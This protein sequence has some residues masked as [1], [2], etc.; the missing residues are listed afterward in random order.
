MK[1]NTVTEQLF[2]GYITAALWSSTDDGGEPLDR[3]YSRS[4]ISD[5]AIEKM[6]ADCT[7]FREQNQETLDAS[8]LDIDQ[9][10]HDFWL[11]RN[12]H[13]AGFWDRNL[14]DIGQKLTDAAHAFGEQNV[15][16]GDDGLLHV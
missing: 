2:H 9:Q 1:T 16:V 4:D 14:G 15:Y 3:N 5:A 11:T 12:R 7:A 10:G 8:G 6:T 13:G